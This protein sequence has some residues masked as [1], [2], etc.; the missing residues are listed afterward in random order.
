M[1]REYAM[2]IV[3]EHDGLLTNLEVLD[4]LRKR[5]QHRLEHQ[6]A[7]PKDGAADGA[8]PR[9]S[10]DRDWIEEKITQYLTADED[11][12][13]ASLT[14]ET[15]QHILAQ[16]ESDSAGSQLKDA[17][18]LQLLNLRPKQPVEVYLVVEEAEERLTEDDAERLIRLTL[19]N[20]GDN[21]GAD[22]GGAADG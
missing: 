11:A 15:A 13:A 8:V 6:P 22:G 17:E 12:P 5:Q 18:R 14:P 21:G 4:H 16:L 10:S 1:A 2:E 9:D 7:A 20:G 3:A 19:G